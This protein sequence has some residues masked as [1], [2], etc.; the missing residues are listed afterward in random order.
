MKARIRKTGEII[1]L[2][3]CSGMT[4][5]TRDENYDWVDYIDSNGNEIRHAKL[6]KYWD[7]E[8]VNETEKDID[9]ETRRFELIKAALQGCCANHNPDASY[10]DVA[11]DA[12]MVADAVI[13]KLKAE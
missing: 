4:S 13:E 1:D 10:N 12:I 6:N 11:K 3:S 5:T 2:V 8:F 9:W 7:L